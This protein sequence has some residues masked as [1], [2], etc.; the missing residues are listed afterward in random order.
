MWLQG[1]DEVLAL[2][3]GRG[4]QQLAMW[5]GGAGQELALWQGGLALWQGGLA[6]WHRGLALCHEIASQRLLCYKELLFVSKG[7]GFEELC[8]SDSAAGAIR[9][10]PDVSRRTGICSLF[11]SA[12]FR[13]LLCLP[14]SCCCS[15]SSTVSSQIS[16]SQP[17]AWFGRHPRMGSS[18][19][20]CDPSFICTVFGWCYWV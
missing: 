8:L 18:C 19:L 15:S 16:M 17:Q 13:C 11:T 10:E 6:L 2:R 1:V 7:C 12:A 9:T 3:H 4:D 5:H 14:T 20:Y